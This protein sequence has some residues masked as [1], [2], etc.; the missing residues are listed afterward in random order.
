MRHDLKT[1]KIFTF[2]LEDKKLRTV[3]IEFDTFQEQKLLSFDIVEHKMDANEFPLI[4]TVS[5]GKILVFS[6]LSGQ[7][8]KDISEEQTCA[9]I[10][11]Y[12]FLSV[13]KGFGDNFYGST[14]GNIVEFVIKNKNNRQK[15]D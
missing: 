14:R 8:L 11:N 10:R 3:A 7:L 5:S 1:V 4:V 15:R 12:N 6:M 2:S 13:A 9:K